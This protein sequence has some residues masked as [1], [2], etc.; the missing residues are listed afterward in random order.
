MTV[1]KK[2]LGCGVLASTLLLGLLLCWSG[3]AQA[4]E[5]PEKYQDSVKKGLD[6]LVKTQFKD[7]HWGANGDNYPVSMTGLAGIAMLMEGSTV[8][9]GKY[10]KEIR[11]AADWLMDRSMRAQ[12][13]DGLIGNPDH[14]TEAGRYMY[15]HGFATLFLAC[16][17]GDEEDRERREKLKDILT[18]A[19]K[20]IGDAQSTQGGWFY[21]SAKD[22]HDQD[23]GSVTITQMQALRAA[24]NAGIAVEKRI[25]KKG[26]DYLKNSTTPRGGVVYSLGRG[27]VGAP[28]GGERPALTA[29]AIACLFS[30]GEYKNELCKKWFKYCQTAIPLAGGGI[31]LGH[32]E[33]TH[34]YYAQAV[35]SLGDDG[36]EKLFGSTPPEQR[37][38]WKK[39]REAMFDNLVR[40]QNGDGSWPSAGGFSVGPVYSTAVYCTI[41]QLDRGTLPF[42]QRAIGKSE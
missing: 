35:Y 4:D 28:A 3:P 2:I 39:Y 18:R 8:R 10:A 17:Y 29:A 26:N 33:Y 7:G 19:C 22:G 11:K 38:T 42:Y 21:T 15:G 6:Y 34:Y 16:V 14:P 13:K 12:N 9:E 32:D 31:R 40:T 36:W 30:A 5:L 23:E 27:G 20:Y 24:R 1:R 25:V 37:V 41:M